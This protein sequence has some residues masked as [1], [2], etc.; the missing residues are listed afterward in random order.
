[1]ESN[2]IFSVCSFTVMIAAV[3]LIVIA[4]YNIFKNQTERETEIGVIQRQIKGFALVFIAN[5]VIVV[6]TMLCMRSTF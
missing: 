6:G 5:L 3:I 1:M 2:K 4:F